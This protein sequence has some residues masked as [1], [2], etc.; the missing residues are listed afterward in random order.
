[1]EKQGFYAALKRVQLEQTFDLDVT[2]SHQGEVREVVNVVE[3]PPAIGPEQT[4]SQE[5]LTGVDIIDIP[6]PVTRDYRNVLN[7]IPS[8]VNDLTG[9]PHVAAAETYET[10]ALLDGFNVTQP[11]NGQLLIRVSTDAFRSINVQTSRYSAEYG[12]GSGGVI[13]LVTGIGDDRFR[14]ITTDFI[15]SVQN[16]KGLELDKV[17]P[18]FTVS[19]PIRKGKVWFFDGADGEYDNIVVPE[20]SSGQDHDT[21]WRVGNLGKLQ[22]NLTSRNI[23][24][25]SFD[26]NLSRNQFGVIAAESALGEPGHPRAGLSGQW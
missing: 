22:A 5:Q 8:V 1:V 2:L 20:L 25:T 17:T 16:K 13:D 19:G 26:Y 3:S 23:L 12:K 24:T 21:F 7:Y 6:Y 4:A 15:P 10:L 11:A 14:F 18:R 9:Q